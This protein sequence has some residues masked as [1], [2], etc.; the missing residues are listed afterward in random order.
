[1]YTCAQCAIQACCQEAPEKMPKNQ[2]MTKVIM[3]IR[4]FRHAWEKITTLSLK[5]LD[6]AVRMQSMLRASIM[7]ART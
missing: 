2:P 4:A 7:E 3:G 6:L 5:P 1:M